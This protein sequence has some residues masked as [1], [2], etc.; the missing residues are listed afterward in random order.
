MHDLTHPP[1]VI[2]ANMEM[3]RDGINRGTLPIATPM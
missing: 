2:P 1:E 3:V